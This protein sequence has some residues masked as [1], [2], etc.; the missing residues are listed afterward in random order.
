MKRLRKISPFQGRL[1][2][3]Q[4]AARASGFVAEHKIE[5]LFL[6]TLIATL[7]LLSCTYTYFVVS[8]SLAVINANAARAD[9]IKLEGAVGE[10]E[11]QYFAMSKEVTPDR[12]NALDL[13]P[14]SNVSYVRRPSEAATLVLKNN[15][16]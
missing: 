4:S 7:V 15:A 5:V 11:Q 13:A 16:L 3:S 12:A 10:A 9:A 1:D 14:V 6:R 2:F 8:S